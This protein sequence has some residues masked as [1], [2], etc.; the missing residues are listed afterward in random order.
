MNF[1]RQLALSDTD[2]K[3][4]E[5]ERKGKDKPLINKS[6]FQQKASTKMA[7]QSEKLKDINNG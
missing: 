2:H 1:N 7:M 3:K 5:R 4:G 6:D